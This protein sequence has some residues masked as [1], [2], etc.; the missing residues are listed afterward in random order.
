MNR[1]KEK[2]TN[3]IVP[4]LMKKHNYKTVME[5]PK[6]EKIVVNMG[7]GDATANAKL[8]EAAVNDLSVI[9]G[10]KPVITKAKKSIAGFKI[11]EGQEIGCKVTLRGEKMYSE[12][13]FDDVVKVRGMDIVLVTT[14]KSNEEALDL[15][16]ELGIPFRK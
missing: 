14:A 1:L 6:L 13:E 4:S 9:T 11:R 3:E 7:V 16:T 15:L 5:V 2:Y 10:Q 8:M 12:I